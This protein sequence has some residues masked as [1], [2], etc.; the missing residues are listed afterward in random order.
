MKPF[1]LE[2]ALAG[3]PL[4]TRD[5]RWWATDF[6]PRADVPDG[7]DKKYSVVINGLEHFVREDGS[8][9]GR[10]FSSAYDLHMSEVK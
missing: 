8:A 3:E 10:E 2:K 4:V 1:D 6:K 5:G 7:D 9:Y